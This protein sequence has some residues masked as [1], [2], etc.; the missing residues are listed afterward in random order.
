MTLV[1]PIIVMVFFSA[2]YAG[3]YIW[4]R[5]PKFGDAKEVPE[6]SSSTLQ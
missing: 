1:I 2:L 3:G 4:M 5:R 6:E